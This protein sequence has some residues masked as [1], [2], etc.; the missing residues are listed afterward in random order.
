MTGAANWRWRNAAALF[1]GWG[2]D[3]QLYQ[4]LADIADTPTDR[5]AGSELRTG[6]RGAPLAILRYVEVGP[7][8]VV[9]RV[10]LGYDDNGLAVVHVSRS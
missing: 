1:D 2:H 8:R 3:P 7:R 9:F 4:A 6:A 10:A 5:L